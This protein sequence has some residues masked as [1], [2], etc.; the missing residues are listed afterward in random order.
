M[1]NCLPT[2]QMGTQ[3]I[4]KRLFSFSKTPKLF[5]ILII[6]VVSEI[7]FQWNHHNGDLK[8]IT[9]GCS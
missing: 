8:C 1:H 2:A 3:Y 4:M 5:G 7:L 6:L 9:G